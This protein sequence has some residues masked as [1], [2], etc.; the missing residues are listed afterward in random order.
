MR[1]QTQI[2]SSNLHSLIRELNFLSSYLRSSST[3]FFPEGNT[4]STIF[5]FDHLSFSSLS[6]AFDIPSVLILTM[7]DIRSLRLEIYHTML[8]A[9]LHVY[10]SGNLREVSNSHSI[11]RY[12]LA[13]SWRPSRGEFAHGRAE[14]WPR[15]I[16]LSHTSKFFNLI[17][18]LQNVVT[19]HSAVGLESSL[20]NPT[21]KT[22]PFVFIQ[23]VMSTRPLPHTR[24]FK[25]VFRASHHNCE[26]SS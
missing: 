12:H 2:H 17:S 13:A 4:L 1:L 26:V 21:T 20:S 25:R 5:C 10:V 15:D 18:L 3:S 24:A 23:I 22:I 16:S 9:V 11:S 8:E 6:Y 19:G 14:N 7:P